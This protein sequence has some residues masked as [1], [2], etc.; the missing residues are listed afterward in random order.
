MVVEH[1]S[2]GEEIDADALCDLYIPRD[3]RWYDSIYETIV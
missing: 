1:M 2:G 3:R